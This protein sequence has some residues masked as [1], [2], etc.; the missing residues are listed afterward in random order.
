MDAVDT[1]YAN[2]RNN[3]IEDLESHLPL[4]VHRYELRDEACPP[5]RWR[6]GIGSVREVE[7]LE[8]GGV[9]VE[10]EGHVHAPWGF[11]GGSSGETAHMSFRPTQGN[12]RRLPSKL[13]N[14]STRAGDRI[15]VVGPSGGGYGNPFE[16]DPIQVCEDVIDGYLSPERA[17]TDYG[18][19]ITEE[20]TVDDAA[21]TRS[22]A[23]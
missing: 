1:L 8:D 22:R 19:V 2:T 23:G 9:S 10:G 11:D 5:G 15:E 4:R 14:L 7:F 13:P 21:T 12:E 17:L 3:P 16:R 18:V 20:L 6:G